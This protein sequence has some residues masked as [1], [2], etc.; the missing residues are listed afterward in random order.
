MTQSATLR[1]RSNLPA[2]LTALVLV[3]AA[4]FT[5]ALQAGPAAATTTTTTSPARTA[6]AVFVSKLQAARTNHGLR[7]LTVRADLVRVA[8]A[9]ATRMATRNR[10]YHNPR[11][12]TDVRSWVYVGENVGYGPTA[13]AVHRAF[14]HSAPHRANILDH[15]YTEV[16]MG[17]VI[18]NGRV[19]V[20]QVF[21]KPA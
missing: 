9:Q 1:T 20:A 5:G 15:D 12:T 10:L 14:M 21:R 19:W 7:R 13:T 4:C 8:R 17:V 2:A 16:G 6:E 11:L 18:V 3:L